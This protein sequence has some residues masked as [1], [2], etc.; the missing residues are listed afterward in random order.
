MRDMAFFGRRVD[1]TFAAEIAAPG[2]DLNTS[3]RRLFTTDVG[4]VQ[5]VYTGEVGFAVRVDQYVTNGPFGPVV[6]YGITA[7]ARYFY[8]APLPF[9]PE[10]NVTMFI[11]SS[12]EAGYLMTSP[13]GN[14]NVNYH[15]YND[16]VDVGYSEFAFSGTNPT[17]S[18]F[19][20]RIN[21]LNLQWDQN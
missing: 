2:V 11:A 20:A 5:I 14:R 10:V 4:L 13:S 9:I 7:S 12:F 6:N 19:V 3:G 16:H 8:P 17:V 15:A 21:V 18:G 1:G